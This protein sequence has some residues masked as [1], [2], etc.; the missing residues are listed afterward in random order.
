MG[1]ALKK[2]KSLEIEATES[3][4]VGLSVNDQLNGVGQMARNL[5]DDIATQE[6]GQGTALRGAD[7]E[8]VDSECGRKIEN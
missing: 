6:R 1:R 5:G 4:W 7:Q 8:H 2:S 3:R